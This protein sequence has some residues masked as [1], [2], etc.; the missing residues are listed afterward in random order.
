MT[1][2]PVCDCIN[3]TMRLMPRIPK[4]ILAIVCWMASLPG[5][6]A[7]PVYVP[8]N[9]AA[10]HQLSLIQAGQAANVSVKG[11]VTFT[12]VPWMFLFVQ[13]DTGGLFC[14][15]SKQVPLPK[16][17]TLVEILG[18]TDRGE[19]L[20]V[21]QITSVKEL[22][23]GSYPAA[24]LASGG[25]LWHGDFDCQWV[26]IE[27]A[28]TAS[29]I[30][31]SPIPALQLDLSVDGQPVQA[32]VAGW[33]ERGAVPRRA[34]RVA[35]T[36]VASTL[37]DFGKKVIGIRILSPEAQLLTPLEESAE[38]SKKLPKRSIQ[39]LLEDKSFDKRPLMRT[40]GFVTQVDARELYVHDGRAGLRITAPFGHE[41]KE[42]DQVDMVV[43][44]EAES[45]DRS[46]ELIHVLSH[47]PK[48]RPEPLNLPASSL[49]DWSHFGRIVE[50]DG[51]FLHRAPT[52]ASALLVL[53][54]GDT[55]FE[56]RVR[57][58]TTQMI[59][60]LAAGTVI[61]ARGVLR[62]YRGPSEKQTVARILVS[63][64]ESIKVVSSPP[65][66]LKQTLSVVL[67]LCAM[68]AVG[69]IGLA[70]AHQRL[71]RSNDRVAAAERELKE[72]NMD[73]ERRIELRTAQLKRLNQQLN[74]EILDRQQAEAALAD[75]ESRLQDAQAIAHIGS[76]HWDAI[77][78]KVSWSR[79]L[80]RIYGQSPEGFNATYEAYLSQI[81][82][83]DRARVE[84]TI[85]TTFQGA[86]S[87]THDYRIVRP[88]GE[89]RWVAAVG[90]ALRDNAGNLIGLEGTCQD[91]TEA[92][93]SESLKQG[94]TEVLEMI[95]HGAPLHST[96][97][98]LV[99]NLEKQSPELLCSILLLDDD[100][101][102]LRHG[103]APSLPDDYN[104]KI[105]GYAIGPCAGSCGTAAFR[106]QAV[107]VENIETDPL[108]ENARALALGAGLKSCWSTP[109]FD[110]QDNVLG[111]FAV[112]YRQPGL[113]TEAHRRLI[114]AATHT[115]AICI[116]RDRAE[117]LQAS[118][119]V[120]L[121]HSQKMEAIGTLAGGI[122]HDFNNILGAIIGY[123]GL[124]QLDVER[125]SEAKEHLNHLQQAAQRARELIRLILTFGRRE[126]LQRQVIEITPLVQESVRM[127]RVAMPPNVEIQIRQRNPA[128][129]ILG[130]PTQIQQVLMNLAN[131]AAQAIG[132]NE[133][134]IIL[135]V[136]PARTHLKSQSDKGPVECLRL[137]VTDNGPGIP[138]AIQERIFEPFFT[139]KG[140][141]K[142]TGLGLAVVHGIVDAHG[143]VIT[144]Q[145]EP[146]RGARFIVDL[147]ALKSTPTA[148]GGATV[149][150]PSA[151]SR[152]A[153]APTMPPPP[154][155][156]HRILLVDDEQSLLKIGQNLLS[157][158][159]FKV[160]PFNDPISAYQAFQTAPDSFDLVITD[161][162][163]GGM[164]G[165]ELAAR[166]N[167][168]RPEMPVIIC[169]GHGAGLANEMEKHTGFRRILHK[170]VEFEELHATVCSALGVSRNSVA[171]PQA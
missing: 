158:A 54:D 51:E 60:R 32:L 55:T 164:S 140:P 6:N 105:D 69:L 83:D 34:S 87:F 97:E 119:E 25:Q 106:R 157:R 120:R 74:N 22:G 45:F 153:S 134:C 70:I 115:A 18:T 19:Y 170:P 28:V 48:Q 149:T 130:D 64:D 139:T 38:F 154:A 72:L 7:D 114:Q 40:E 59:N 93:Q 9:A 79:E 169:T 36:G 67:T 31:T 50:V 43:K 33:A 95:A 155:G 117:K 102:H 121:R 129:R 150:T 171:S 131:N 99:V 41:L 98:K 3:K 86:Q 135:D 66:P 2:P 156:E 75:R 151:P 8:T 132:Q 100:G 52:S 10:I 29:L 30:S 57:T 85:G 133:G 125:P 90:R 94:Q 145:S 42:G 92:K 126:D 61:R 146:G 101:Q 113:P 159:G 53:K 122:A 142:G 46:V 167:E 96:L 37:T 162:T 91:V 104:R 111:T 20:P 124:A 147:P 161:H 141:G 165:V 21:L 47:V 123:A 152:S 16:P 81:H 27:G 108:W 4:S 163:M 68:V 44:P 1:R 77:S 143:G 109:I 166:I 5:A 118:L 138:T 13:D 65:W 24:K 160:V 76:F 144:L 82:P 80:F 148:E 107:V 14:Y 12:H 127:L 39:T 11:V 168:I 49:N 116:A 78:N 112:Y 58:N 110:G 56:A 26:R 35:I 103:A 89:I 71:R 23:Q 17:G 15:S 136:G 63:S 84:Q 128:P 73:L 62:L 88:G 137:T